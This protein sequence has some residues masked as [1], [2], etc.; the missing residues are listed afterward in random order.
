MLP[1]DHHM[2]KLGRV[3]ARTDTDRPPPLRPLG[4]WYAVGSTYTD[5]TLAPEE[6]ILGCPA[7]LCGL[8]CVPIG[9]SRC[10]RACSS[11]T[12]SRLEAERGP[13][14]TVGGR[15]VPVREGLRNSPP[16]GSR[17]S[18][19]YPGLPACGLPPLECAARVI[20]ADQLGQSRAGYWCL[21]CRRRVLVIGIDD[22]VIRTRAR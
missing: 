3:G 19:W 5:V 15:E 21:L 14:R 20:S 6:C 1:T 8:R 22:F 13:R 4:R 12:M 7:S 2:P 11:R 10:E 17:C 18:M 16:R 9:R